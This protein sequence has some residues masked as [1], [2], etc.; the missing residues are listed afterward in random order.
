MRTRSRINTNRRTLHCASLSGSSAVLSVAEGSGP[1]ITGR[2]W[3]VWNEVRVSER[4]QGQSSSEGPVD[5]Q[6][7]PLPLQ[8]RSLA[9]IWACSSGV[10]SI[11]G[12]PGYPLGNMVRFDTLVT[13]SMNVGERK[14]RRR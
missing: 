12:G 3:A 5:V 9:R 6:M 14:F 8:A 1:R 10:G 4:E 11:G 2:R 13:L 7:G